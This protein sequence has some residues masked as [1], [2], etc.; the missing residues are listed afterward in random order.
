MTGSRQNSRG[1]LLTFM[2]FKV[3]YT[4]ETA[5]HSVNPYSTNFGRTNS[6]CFVRILPETSAL[7]SPAAQ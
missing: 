2:G 3:D 5:I 4:D 1:L 7:T 6:Q